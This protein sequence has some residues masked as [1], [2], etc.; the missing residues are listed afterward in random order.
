MYFDSISPVMPSH[1]IYKTSTH[2]IATGHGLVGTLLNTCAVARVRPVNRGSRAASQIR[3]LKPRPMRRLCFADQPFPETWFVED[4]RVLIPK[5]FHGKSPPCR[6]PGLNA[7]L[8]PTLL[9]HTLS[10][11]NST[12]RSPLADDVELSAFAMRCRSAFAS[13]SATI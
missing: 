13:R 5:V 7:E 4:D 2:T 10:I 3:N 8:F 9:A 11:R 1:D 12:S 6:R